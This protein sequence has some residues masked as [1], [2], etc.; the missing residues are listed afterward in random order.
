MTYQ[1]WMTDSIG[2]DCYVV[3]RVSFGV[4]TALVRNLLGVVPGGNV[5]MEED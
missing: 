3:G 1:V 2:N 5:W 4:A